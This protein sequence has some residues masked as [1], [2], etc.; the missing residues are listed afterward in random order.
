MSHQKYPRLPDAVANLLTLHGMRADIVKDPVWSVA[1]RSGWAFHVYVDQPSSVAREPIFTIRANA[2]LE[3][4][5]R[6]V[7]MYTEDGMPAEY[8]FETIEKNMEKYR[9]PIVLRPDALPKV[10]EPVVPRN[11]W[12]WKKYP[13]RKNRFGKVVSNHGVT[14]E[15]EIAAIRA[16]QR[17][18]REYTRVLRVARAA[19][20][21]ASKYVTEDHRALDQSDARQGRQ[22]LQQR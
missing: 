13:T 3:E 18:L 1:V 5:M 17:A 4:W 16:R 12:P 21:K 22:R 2:P 19:L 7:G 10:A 20:K 15:E 8:F 9:G 11:Y 14:L 6:V